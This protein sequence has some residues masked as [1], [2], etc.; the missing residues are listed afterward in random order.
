MSAP[1]KRR[2]TAL[3]RRT[4]TD[5]F[6]VS[7]ALTSYQ[8]MRD[9]SDAELRQFLQCTSEDFERLALCRFPDDR[10]ARF[11]DQVER[12]AAYAHCDIDRLLELFREVAAFDSLQ[13]GQHDEATGLLLAA[14]D[15]RGP[16]RKTGGGGRRRKRTKK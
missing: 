5:S 3:I 2:L 14:R 7:R 6:F 8:S 10:D 4:R 16:S 9:L 11:R 1:R 13:G 15:R 12:I